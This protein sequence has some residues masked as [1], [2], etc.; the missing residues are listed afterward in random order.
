[1]ECTAYRYFN[2]GELVDQELAQ[3]ALAQYHVV[4]D[5]A[6]QFPIEGVDE[7]EE[8][9]LVSDR[10]KVVLRLAVDYNTLARQ[11]SAEAGA[12][13]E[14]SPVLSII[15]DESPPV[16]V[17]FDCVLVQPVLDGLS[18]LEVAVWA[19]AEAEVEYLCLKVAYLAY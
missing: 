5:V 9:G 15:V 6:A 3:L 18:E 11:I 4:H 7:V 8:D 2:W 14:S 17:Y 19:R 16:V 12:N 10:N 1:L 13:K